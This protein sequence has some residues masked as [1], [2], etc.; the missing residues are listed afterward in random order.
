MNSLCIYKIV[1]VAIFNKSHLYKPAE[2]HGQLHTTNQSF[3]WDH[4]CI[5]YPVGWAERL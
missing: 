4:P 1:I 2:H 5:N 3:H